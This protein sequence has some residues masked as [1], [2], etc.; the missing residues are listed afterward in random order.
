MPVKSDFLKE[1]KFVFLK[2]MDWRNEQEMNN[3]KKYGRV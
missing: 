1:Y 2:K 3:L